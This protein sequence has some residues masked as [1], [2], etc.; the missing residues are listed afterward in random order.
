MLSSDEPRD[1]QMRP[2]EMSCRKPTR[3]LRQVAFCEPCRVRALMVPSTRGRIGGAPFC[4]D[5]RVA[6]V[7]DAHAA[8][9]C[10]PAVESQADRRGGRRAVAGTAARPHAAFLP[11]TLDFLSRTW[12]SE[13]YARLDTAA[14]PA[15]ASH[16]PSPPARTPARPHRSPRVH[17]SC[18]W[19][20]V[21][22]ARPLSRRA[23][24]ERRCCMHLWRTGRS[25]TLSSLTQP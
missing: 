8:P 20:P 10:K 17:R 22:P 3:R 1:D 4:G 15:D 18:R 9:L 11:R 14:L 16:S 25:A 24:S 19:L 23:C 7:R 2:E 12:P 5:R 21:V 13:L 6:R